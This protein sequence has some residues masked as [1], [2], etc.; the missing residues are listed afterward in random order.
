M[1]IVRMI[2]KRYGAAVIMALA[3]G[4]AFRNDVYRRIVVCWLRIVCVAPSLS[5]L[6]ATIFSRRFRR[7]VHAVL[8]GRLMHLQSIHHGSGLLFTLRRNIHRIEKGLLMRPRQAVFA[9]SYIQL[10]VDAY[11][12]ASANS[13]LSRSAAETILWASDVLREYFSA[14]RSHPII[15]DARRLFEPK[16]RVS[17]D[18]LRIPKSL[19]P[20][21]VSV[22][23][24]NAFRSLCFRR[25]S[26]RWFLQEPVPRA[27]LDQAFEIA[28]LAPS[29]CNRQPYRFVVIDD[30]QA[31]VKLA[32][33][34]AGTAGYG[35]QVP[36]YVVVIGDLAAYFDERDRHVIYVDGA[37]ASMNFMLALETI[38]LSSCP[39]NWPDIGDREKKMT[40]FLGL[41]AWERPVLVL[42]VG[43]AEPE[44]MVAYSQRKSL[45]EIRTYHVASYER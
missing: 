29:A 15:E 34:P 1:N 11:T 45:D 3:R 12:R 38:G 24:E 9:L 27:L 18:V 10:T 25:K 19:H 13:E 2:K 5:W 33:I 41:H 7:E 14:V 39:I 43:Y 30:P 35:R 23:D 4:E 17:S 21:P 44:G 16:A 42:G 40:S 26:V 28:G 31:A 36:A 20:R 6:H 8:C 32:E 37:L 22:P